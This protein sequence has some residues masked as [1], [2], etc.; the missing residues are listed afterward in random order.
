MARVKIGEL[1][2]LVSHDVRRAAQA[3]TI[4][5]VDRNREVAVLGPLR[6]TVAR[7]GLWGCMR[8]SARIAGDLVQSSMT[9]EPWFRS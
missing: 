4:T 3:E 5:V 2:D 7:G 9:E 1:R 6:K 8:G